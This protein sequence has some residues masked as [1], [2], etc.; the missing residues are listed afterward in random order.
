MG[1]KA[2]GSGGSALVTPRMPNEVYQ[3]VLSQCHILLK[4]YYDLVKTPIEAPGKK[5]YGDV[6]FLVAEPT[7]LAQDADIKKV[8]QTLKSS[9]GATQIRYQS[10][11]PTASFA[12]PWPKEF[13]DVEI[14]NKADTDDAVCKGKHFV[15]V[16]VHICPDKSAWEWELFQH[17][18]GDLWCILGSMIRNLGLT[19][20]N[21][22]LFLRV[23][24]IDKVDR[25]KSMILLST[26]PSEVLGFLGLDEA[27][28]WKRFDSAE[29]MCEYAASCRFFWADDPLTEIAQDK[30]ELK[31]NDRRRMSQR[32]IFAM[33]VEKYVPALRAAGHGR[34]DRPSREQVKEE[35][36]ERF[37]DIRELYNDKLAEFRKLQ[38]REEVWRDLIKERV[39]REDIDLRFRTGA[40]RGLKEIILENNLSLGVVPPNSLQAEDGSFIME[41]VITFIERNWQEIGRLNCSWMTN[42]QERG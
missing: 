33:W 31:H 40:I 25:K 26:K 19:V 32:P 11:S 35:A 5:D 39:P 8:Y 18:H 9:L 34:K 29:A 42:N 3:L 14:S 13:Q 21:K 10:G 23:Q 30:K 36:F 16:D 24:E 38:Q 37:E 27:Q 28:W 41:E 20:N 1:G 22:A 4:K 12:L 15:Q 6:D 7:E 17:A 2:F